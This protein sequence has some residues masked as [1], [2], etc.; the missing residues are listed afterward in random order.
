MTGEDQHHSHSHGTDRFSDQA[1]NWD[2]RPG[3][4]DRAGVIAAAIRKRIP[5]SRSV[6]ALEI[7]GG[8]GL[9]A[10]ALAGDIGTAV[11]TDVASGM[12]AVARTVLAEERYAGWR[13]ERFDVEHDP[14]PDE[15]FDVVLSQL[16]L[17]HMGD[18]PKVIARVFELTAPGGH[19]ALADLEKDA[20]GGFHRHVHDFDGHHGF[21]REALAG[22]LRDAGFGDVEV[23]VAGHDTK[24]VDGVTRD[25]PV[26]LAT[27]QRPASTP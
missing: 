26:L 9:L 21:T 2:E 27:G 25:F 23:Q 24:V 3:A 1:S 14:L 7:G 4:A 20:D 11:V 5:L 6:S 22:W 10:R 15:R 18:V 17:H 19:V 8:T 13:A 16:A 12:V